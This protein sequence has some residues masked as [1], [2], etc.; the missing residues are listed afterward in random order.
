M[1]HTGRKLLE[2]QAEQKRFDLSRYQCQ[3]AALNIICQAVP[4]AFPLHLHCCLECFSLGVRIIL[5]EVFLPSIDEKS[6][7][8]EL[9][10]GGTLQ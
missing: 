3:T 4:V 6:P 10:K 8:A 5:P 1:V 7:N 9:R 2:N